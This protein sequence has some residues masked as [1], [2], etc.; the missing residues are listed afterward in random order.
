MILLISVQGAVAGAIVSVRSYDGWFLLFRIIYRI[1]PHSLIRKERKEKKRMKSKPREESRRRK[2][3]ND[4]A[5]GKS[6]N[7]LGGAKII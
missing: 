4:G 2:G 1:Y 3:E 6:G 5:P 7:K